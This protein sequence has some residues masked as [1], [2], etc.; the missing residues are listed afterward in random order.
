MNPKMKI[1][2][3]LDLDTVERQLRAAIGVYA[4]TVAKR[5]EAEAKQNAK[6][7]NRTSNARNSIRG[8]FGWRD[9]K[10][11]IVL[12]GGMDYS[13]WLE[14]ANG[15]RYAILVPTME[16]NAAAIIKGYKRLVGG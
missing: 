10:C 6:W 3:K 16:T 5:L 11:R 13:V 1:T 15:K 9:N 7:I 14:L 8:T 4:D 12:S 2:R